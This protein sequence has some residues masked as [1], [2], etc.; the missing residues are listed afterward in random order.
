MSV[1]ASN[2]VLGPARLYVAAFGSAEPADSTVT[3]NG[4][5][6]PPGSP[7]TDVGGTDGGVNFEVDSTYTPLA[8][9]QI[10]MDVGARLTEIKFQVTAKL[11]E[12]TLA[13]LNTAMNSIGVTSGGTGYST[14]DIPVGSAASQ[15]TYAALIIDGWAPFTASGAPALR[16]VIVRKVLAQTKAMLSYDKK[17]Q[18]G[19]ECTW[20][21][22][23]VSSSINPVHIIDQTS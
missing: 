17:S 16:R 12:V 6:T 2:L 7:W 8:V 23:F 10:I 1:T 15:P 3:P 5:T 19:Y 11:S 9:D 21:A 4:T 20:A 13:N 18:L 14:L 22:Y